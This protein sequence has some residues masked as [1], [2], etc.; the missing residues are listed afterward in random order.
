MR[1]YECSD[2][3]LRHQLRHMNNTMF[4]SCCNY[5]VDLITQWSVNA[6]TVA[7]SLSLK[8]SAKQSISTVND[9]NVQWN[10]LKRDRIDRSNW[11][12]T[13]RVVRSSTILTA[14]FIVSD[15][16]AASHR[17]PKCRERS[18]NQL[19]ETSWHGTVNVS[20]LSCVYIT[21]S[22]LSLVVDGQIAQC[23]PRHGDHYVH[24]SIS[25]IIAMIEI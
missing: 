17:R 22:Q 19:A 2:I 1:V 24:S 14:H 25:H 10:V 15:R 4:T 23:N 20:Q 11:S 21:L 5:N 6:A 7:V 3:H 9:N 16:G 12:K 13:L 18:V 8:L